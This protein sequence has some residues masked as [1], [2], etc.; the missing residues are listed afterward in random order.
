[1]ALVSLISAAFFICSGVASATDPTA[2]IEVVPPVTLNPD[3]SLTVTVRATCVPLD[4]YKGL[5]PLADVIVV[6]KDG[7]SYLRGSFGAV[8]VCD[9]MAHEYAIRVVP[10]EP[11]ARFHG[12][13]VDVV[14]VISACGF[15]DGALVCE[16]QNPPAHSETFIVRG[17]GAGH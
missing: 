1:L 15:L 17:A 8:A 5:P 10:D 4:Q 3:G 6:Q 7:Q 12:G 14:A 11:S 9:N 16:Q 13:P 2:T